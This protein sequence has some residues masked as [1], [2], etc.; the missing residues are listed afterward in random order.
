M[1]FFQHF[2]FSNL[3]AT[4]SRQND[5][6]FQLRKVSI[7]VFLGKVCKMWNVKCDRFFSFPHSPLGITQSIPIHRRIS[8]HEFLFI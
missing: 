4:A 1:A 5:T 6:Y 8:P 7:W 2:Q 3:K